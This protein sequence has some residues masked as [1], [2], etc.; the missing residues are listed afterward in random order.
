M[1]LHEQFGEKLV[2]KSGEQAS[3]DVLQGK[4]VV[5]IYFSAHWCPPCRQFTP[6]LAELYKKVRAEHGDNAFEIVF[7][8]G[9]S[10]ESSFNE[11]YGEMPWTAAP[12]KGEASTTLDTKYEHRGI[13]FLVLLDAEGNKLTEDARSTLMTHGAAAYPWSKDAIAAALAA[14]AEKAKDFK[15]L[16]GDGGELRCKGGEAIKDASGFGG[17]QVAVVRCV[18][19]GRMRGYMDQIMIPKSKEL[20]EKVACV[21]ICADKEAGGM[22]GLM[23][24]LPGG[25]FYAEH[26]SAAASSALD[27]YSDGD[28]GLVCCGADGTVLTEDKINESAQRSAEAFPWSQEVIDAALAVKRAN[29]KDFELLGSQL[30]G[31]AGDVG[32]A[33]ALADKDY[34][35]L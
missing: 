3:A 22:A 13:P 25:W 15:P 4:A 16:F 34:V 32:T 6:V 20:A 2:T 35:L 30:A 28:I 10:D 31:K 5:G 21:Y 29:M 23:D 7:V 18:T 12:Y 33:A 14:R 1:A 26:G 27:S 24:A 8:S 19:Q 9:D 17:K 11:Y